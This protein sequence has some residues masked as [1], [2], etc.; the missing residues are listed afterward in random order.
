[1]ATVTTLHP[2]LEDRTAV[3]LVEE[4]PPTHLPMGA[5]R[6]Q[7]PRHGATRMHVNPVEASVRLLLGTSERGIPTASGAVFNH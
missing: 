3:R 2:P 7:L 4:F 1:M 5:L 6:N